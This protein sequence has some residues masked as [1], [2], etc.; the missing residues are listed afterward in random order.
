MPEETDAR[1]ELKVADPK[2]SGEICT[3]RFKKGVGHTDNP[4]AAHAC[5]QFGV[6]VVDHMPPQEE[7]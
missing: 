2:F 5:Q 4:R 7:E 6:A 3:V 1:F